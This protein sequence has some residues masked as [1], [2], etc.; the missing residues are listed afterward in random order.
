MFGRDPA[1]LAAKSYAGLMLPGRAFELQETGEPTS[2][3]G[4]FAA[5]CPR[6]M[7]GLAALRPRTRP[8]Q[9]GI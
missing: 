4:G 3:Q 9:Q 5:Y 2:I 1:F 6:R 7:G 8:D